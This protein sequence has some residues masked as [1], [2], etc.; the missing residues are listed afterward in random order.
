MRTGCA[1]AAI[2][3]LGIISSL[4]LGTEQVTQ[5]LF[6]GRSGI[7]L[8]PERK[9]IGFR[10]GLTGVVKG[11]DP[12]E[13][14]CGAKML[15]TTDE[16]ARYAWA[17]AKSAIEDSGLSD[18]TIRSERTGIIFGNDSCA[19]PVVEAVDILREQGQTHFIGGGNVFRVMNSTVSMNLACAFGTKGA[20]WTLSAACASGA[21]SVGQAA[22]LI[23]AGLQDVV[24]AGGAQ[25]TG[26]AG[27]MSF[28]SLGAF[29]LRE[30]H[31]EHASR[32]FDA[33]RDGLVPSGGA[34]CLVLENAE[35]ARARSARIYGIIAG[36]GFSS[37]GSNHLSRPIVEGALRAMAM[38]LADADVDAQDIDYVN[39]HATSTPVGDRVEA[40]A[41]ARLLGDEVPVSSTKS[42]T[43]HECWMAGAS[44]VVYTTLMAEGGF[45][46]GNVNFRRQEEDAHRINVV[47]KSRECRIRRAISNSFGFGG[48]NAAL[49]LEFEKTG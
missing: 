44:E 41:V 7:I 36:Y 8:E 6:E 40:E 45:V 14:G 46:A 29:S 11:F 16:P 4:G 9:A 24:L 48:T 34:A 23:R 3:G 20:N 37:D 1:Q 26:W 33:E 30:G 47:G 17:A 12:R 49:V 2:T 27:M 28:D 38:A 32:P 5:S 35:K 25:E 13:W 19:A 39:A 42:L 31:P 10:S 43:G 18:E 22:A 21:H 15:R